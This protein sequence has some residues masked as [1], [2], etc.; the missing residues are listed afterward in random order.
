MKRLLQ[1]SLDT[2][3]TSVLPI[4][5]WI[6]LGF[7][8]TKEI[9][10][11]FS[12]TYPLQFFY[13][14]FISLFAVGPNITAKKLKNENVIYSN[15]L[16]GCICVGVLT[17]VLVLNSDIYINIMSMDINV[18]HNF[19][20][21]SMIWMYLSFIMQIIT[22]KLYY[23]TKNKES[24][25]I[26]LVFNL[27]NFFLIIILTI[28]L[29][30]YIAIIIT[31]IIDFI[32]VMYLLFRYYKKTKFCLKFIE[33]VRYTSFNILR[34]VGMFLIYGIGFGNSFSYGEKYATAINFE[35]LTTDTQWDML[36]SVDTASK[37]DLAE[38][39]FNYKESLKNAY[40]LLAVLIGTV[41]I[42]NITLYWYFKPALEVLIII[43]LVQII[44]M[45]IDP[46]KT[47]KWSYL[48][49]NDNNKKHNIFY[50]LSRVIRLLCSFIPTAFCTYIGQ[51]FSMIYLYI[52][53]KIQCRKVEIF[54]IKK[55]NSLL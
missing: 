51:V 35:S 53:S 48:Q 24:N 16:F 40:K 55:E 12:L 41:L 28:F 39:K 30:D 18:Y 33:N 2:L 31:L 17:L 43:L 13:M 14:I 21:Y 26:N 46:I 19:C 23:E 3:L 11:V 45:L 9:S 22:Q 5:M 42:M 1:I 20:I 32:I 27:S 8:I 7:I 36:Y 10:N 25:K 49:I 50:A 44:D 34:N 47:L 54:N 38:N 29:K 52:Y 15:M 4:V 37:I 6:L